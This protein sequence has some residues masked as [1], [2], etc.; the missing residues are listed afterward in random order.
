MDISTMKAGETVEEVVNNSSN[1][2]K[3][4]FFLDPVQEPDYVIPRFADYYNGTLSVEFH[5]G[6]I[7][8]YFD[9][10]VDVFVDFIEAE[11]AGRFFHHHIRDEYEY[12][13]A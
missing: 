13:R 5:S 8:N 1:I 9:V 6:G 4:K 12:K 2:K 10:P 11:S 7:Y 3:I